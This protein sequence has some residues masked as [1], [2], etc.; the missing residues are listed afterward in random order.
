MRRTHRAIRLLM[1]LTSILCTSSVYGNSPGQMPAPQA[2]VKGLYS[3]AKRHY[4]EQAF[5]KALEAIEEVLKIDPFYTSALLL[6]YKALIGLF[7]VPPP[8]TPTEAK[9]PAILRERRIS[10]AKFLIEAADSLEKYLQLKPDARGAELLR[11]QL[12]ALR[13]HAEPAIKPESAWTIFSREEATE[14]AHLLY[15]PEPRYA[16]EARNAQVR[17]TVKLLGVLAA[18]GTV[19]HLLV[20]QGLSHGL[21]ES[22]LE[23]ASR[24]QFT[25]ALKDGRPV[26][27]VMQIEYSYSIY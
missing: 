16:E 15:R 23:A 7:A 12:P 4:E 14:K 11:A 24:I 9:S 21:T 19:K 6:K 25:P 27:S 2:D 22:S 13:A 5:R 17:G 10:R 3:T 8:L 20:L 1:V 26:S 18:D